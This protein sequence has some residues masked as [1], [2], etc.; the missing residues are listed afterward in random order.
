MAT[1]STVLKTLTFSGFEI[2]DAEKGEITAKVATLEV[3]DKDGD[4]IRKSALP[5]AAKV[6]MSSWGHDAMFG[7]RPA[8]KGTLARQG[9]GLVFE[10]KVFLTTTD[11]RETFEVLKE[12]GADQQWSFGFRIS[13]WEN[14]S[15]EERKSGAFRIITKMDAFEVSPV[16]IGA[17][18]GTHTTSVKAEKQEP[19]TTAVTI[20]ATVLEIPTAKL[21]SIAAK[22]SEW[23]RTESD[24]IAQAEAAAVEAALVEAE[25]KAKAEAD[26]EAAR[27]AAEIALVTPILERFQKNMRK[28]A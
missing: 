20:G 7:N 23:L 11:G 6:A 19:E 28:F 10:G 9:D 8:G 4:I 25:A 1:D 12:M 3:V 15:D 21:P 5:K 14:P 24:T 26:A 17:G 2:K 27:K 13:G 22:V 16:L 18:V